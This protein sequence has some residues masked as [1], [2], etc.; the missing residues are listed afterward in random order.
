MGRGRAG[1]RLHDP[2][3]GSW[4]RRRAALVA[5]P[6]PRD[7]RAPG[8]AH[9]PVPPRDLWA[10]TRRAIQ[11]VRTRASDRTPGHHHRVVRDAQPRR[12]PGSE[13]PLIAIGSGVG[14]LA[15]RALK[16]DAPDQAVMLIAG[17]GSFAASST[18]R[19]SPRAGAYVLMGAAGEGAAMTGVVLLPGLLAA[20][21]GALIFV[22][23][24]SLTGFGT[25]SLAVPDLPAFST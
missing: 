4:A 9:H 15:L 11:G 20:G 13:A 10:R 21:I 5:D 6:D 22:G 14:V 25:F 24:D 8:R 1:V 17:A 7:Q 19:G 2:P 18:L 16:R 23:L 3:E 12:R